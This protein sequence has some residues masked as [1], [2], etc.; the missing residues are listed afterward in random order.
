MHQ[1][2]NSVSVQPSI[3]EFPQETS[4]KN[5][6]V[7]ILHSMA[8]KSGAEEIGNCGQG[9]TLTIPPLHISRPSRNQ[10]RSWRRAVWI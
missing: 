7:L 2:V 9:Y 5:E 10:N 6:V 3:V 1:D 4:E 8:E